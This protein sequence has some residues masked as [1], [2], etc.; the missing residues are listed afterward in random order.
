MIVFHFIGVA[1]E[2][3]PSQASPERLQHARKCIVHV[4]GEH[5]NDWSHSAIMIM[6]M[7]MMMMMNWWIVP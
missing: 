6:M 1:V 4:L 2:P 3:M 7:M 5:S